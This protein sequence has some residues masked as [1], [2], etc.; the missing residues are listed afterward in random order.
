MMDPQLVPAF[1]QAARRLFVRGAEH[2]VRPSAL[3]TIAAAIDG[4]PAVQSERTPQLQPVCRYLPDAIA[5]ATNRLDTGFI[6]ALKPLLPYL[7]WHQDYAP[8]DTAVAPSDTNYAAS[9]VCGPRGWI[10]SERV[11]LGLVL[12]GPATCYLPYA[13]PEAELHHIL[14]GQ[15]LW[16][17][18]NGAWRLRV[19]GEF[20]VH[21][22]DVIHAM[23]TDRD[24]LLALYAAW[25]DEGQD[26]SL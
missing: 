17:I 19:G 9:E 4:L 12:L 25:H 1:L 10:V 22:P 11:T 8:E 18:G 21:P 7:H 6:L 15:A 20:I 26:R 3:R 2:S 5:A 24:P 13:R 16:Q 23:K 14:S